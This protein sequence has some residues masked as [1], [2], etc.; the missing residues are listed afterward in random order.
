MRH[1]R[2]VGYQQR[3]C[4]K[5]Y[6]LWGSTWSYIKEDKSL[7]RTVVSSHLQH[8][9]TQELEDPITELLPSSGCLHSAFLM[10]LVWFSVIMSCH[11]YVYIIFWLH[12]YGFQE[13]GGIHRQQGDLVS[14]LLSLQIRKVGQKLM[15]FSL[16]N[17][18]SEVIFED[19]ENIVVVNI[20]YSVWCRQS[21][22]VA[23]YNKLWCV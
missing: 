19:L 7:L 1:M 9:E 3:N 12:Y 10:T 6:F 16:R 17:T 13:F 14:L 15:C 20:L 8:T 23:S 21:H 22:C 2:K 5:Q 18:W 11:I 4:W